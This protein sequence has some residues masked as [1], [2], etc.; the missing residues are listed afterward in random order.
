MT[1]ELERLRRPVTTVRKMRAFDPLQHRDSP[2]RRSARCVLYYNTSCQRGPLRAPVGYPRPVAELGIEP[3][4]ASD[5]F[6]AQ[7][8]AG[9]LRLSL[10]PSTKGLSLPPRPREQG[11]EIC[12]STCTE[13]CSTVWPLHR[14]SGEFPS[15]PRDPHDDFIET[16]ENSAP[17]L[18]SPIDQS[19][20]CLDG[21]GNCLR[22][23]Y[24]KSS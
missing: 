4:T 2:M 5:R 15:S 17:P 11:L 7:P 6:A 13:P 12:L 19:Q 20:R 22:Q 9:R 10:H 8:L 3:N 24:S 14:H 16:G 21:M 1:S 23:V 18:A